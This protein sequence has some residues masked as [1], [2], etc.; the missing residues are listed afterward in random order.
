MSIGVT[1][2]LDV[3]EIDGNVLLIVNSAPGDESEAGRVFD[4]LDG[5][6]QPSRLYVIAT[7]EW[8]GWLRKRGWSGDRVLLALDAV[9]DALE[10][11]YFLESAEAIR[12]IVARRFAAVIGSAPHN[13]YNEEVKDIFE[14]RV[15]FILGAARFLIHTLP[16]PYVFSLSL[17]DL[18]QR[19]NRGQKVAKYE[20]VS[21]TL[22]DDLH[23]AWAESGKPSVCDARSFEDAICALERHLGPDILSWDEASPIPLD[24]PDSGRAAAEFL[25]AA[26]AALHQAADFPS[27]NVMGLVQRRVRRWISK[28]RQR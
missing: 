13:L 22:I 10:L 14:V 7:P 17:P 27:E 4:A 9:G 18:L 12:W 5:C 11:N 2:W 21:R 3:A 26:E 6:V 15:G 28:R 19:F 1:T 23:R 24:P 8:F 25:L 20:A 16:K